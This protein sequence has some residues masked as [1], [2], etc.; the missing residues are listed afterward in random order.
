MS[1]SIYTLSIRVRVLSI[2]PKLP[3]FG[4]VDRATPSKELL[5]GAAKGI[6]TK[7]S[8]GCILHK[9][10]IRGHL[11]NPCRVLMGCLSR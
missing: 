4:Y 9:G 7:I 1:I 2:N 3:K 8:R 10:C 5:K 6:S 11:K